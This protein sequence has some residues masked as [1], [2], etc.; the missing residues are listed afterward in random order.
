VV[1]NYL[2]IKM[3][4]VQCPHCIQI[5]E[6]VEVNCKIFRCGIYR[7]TYLQIPPHL[8]KSRCDFLS[9]NDKIYGCGKPF[10]IVLQSDDTYTSK[11]C[12]Y[13]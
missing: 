12:D 2:I 10:M 6:I 11:V 13:I 7:D 9:N 5:I 1:N 3:L 4:I 8:P